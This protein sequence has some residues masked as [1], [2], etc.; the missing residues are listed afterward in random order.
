MVCAHLLLLPAAGDVAGDG[1][2][3]APS[4]AHL[5]AGATSQAPWLLQ[6]QLPKGALVGS[7]V[8]LSTTT[9]IMNNR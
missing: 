7:F 4:S 5:C 1:I 2:S 9:T 8:L 3:D 6:C